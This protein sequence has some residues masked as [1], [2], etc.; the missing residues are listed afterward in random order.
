MKLLITSCLLFALTLCSA[1]TAQVDFRKHIIV[2]GSAEM[3]V[4]PDEVELEI[5]LGN[6][7]KTGKA[8]DY[9]QV[10]SEFKALMKKHSIKPETVVFDTSDYWHWWYWW[11]DRYNRDARVI[12][13]KV[14]NKTDLLQFIKDLDQQWTVYLRITNSTSKDLQRFRKEVKMEAIKAAKQKAEYLL[15]S[16]GEK[17]GGI[18]AVEEMPEQKL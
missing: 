17:V 5:V 14:D 10:E 12:K 3:I 18:L 6:H 9:S 15:E 8:L 7:K 11:S 16:V 13:L 4:Q 2:N 1:Q